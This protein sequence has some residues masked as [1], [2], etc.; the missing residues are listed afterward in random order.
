MNAVKTGSDLGLTAVRG[1]LLTTVEIADFLRVS[2]R[3]I[4]LHMND[5]TFPFRWYPIGERL[6]AADS[7]D[8]DKW[9]LSIRVEAGSA[10]LPLRR[11]ARQKRE[12]EA[13]M[14]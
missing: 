14:K 5:G 9:L 8:I 12:K 4:N 2:D 10:P 11:R 3:W 1:R 6:H 7:Y 13:A